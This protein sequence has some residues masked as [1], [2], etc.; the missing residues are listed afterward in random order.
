[1]YIYTHPESEQVDQKGH[2]ALEA[3]PEVV[4]KVPEQLRADVPQFAERG[5][6]EK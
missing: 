4:L 6:V 2:V 5:R 3:A 1:M